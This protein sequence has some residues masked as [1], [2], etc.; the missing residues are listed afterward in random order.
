MKFKYY[1]AKDFQTSDN[2][3]LETLKTHYYRARKEE[4]LKVVE[5]MAKEFKC[6]I[7][8]IDEERGEIIFDHVDYN[9]SAIITATTYTEMAIDFVIM[10]YNVLPT[11]PGKKVIEKFYSYIDK[12]LSFKGV[13]LYK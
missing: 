2:H 8:H 6:K 5:E 11:A 13:G 12:K 9:A 10:T 4:A 7:K 1:F 3:E